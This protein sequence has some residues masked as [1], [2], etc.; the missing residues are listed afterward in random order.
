MRDVREIE[1]EREKLNGSMGML[2]E[3]L[4]QWNRTPLHK[5][6]HTD[7]IHTHAFHTAALRC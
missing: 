6:L 7:S 3:L 4:S 2:T 5:N 1:I